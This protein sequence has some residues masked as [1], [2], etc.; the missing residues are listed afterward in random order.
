VL[1]LNSSTDE[2]PNEKKK[3][4]ECPSG[5]QEGKAYNLHGHEYTGTTAS[6]EA[7]H[8]NIDFACKNSVRVL[9]R[10]KCNR[11]ASKL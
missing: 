4:F 11:L 8:V 6:K 10:S 7:S 3:T 2:K 1:I 5:I 9:V